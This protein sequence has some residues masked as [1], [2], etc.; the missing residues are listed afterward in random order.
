MKPFE[1]VQIVQEFSTAGGV[2]TVAWG[3]AGAFSRAGITNAVVAATA[4]QGSD[5]RTDIRR[6]AGWL[7]RVPTRGSLR[8]LGRLIVVPAFSIAATLAARRTPGSII[9]S[10]GDSLIGDILV[11]HAVNAESLAAKRADGQWAWIFNPMHYWIMLRDH[12]MI[13]GLRCKQYVAVSNRVAGE[14]RDHFAVPA[15]RICVIP[16]GIDLERFAH[17]PKARR[18]VRQRHAIPEDARVLLFVGHEFQRKGLAFVLD[19][20]AQL[21]DPPWLMVVGSDNPA[22]YRERAGTNA[23]RVVFAGARSDVD[24]YYSAADA[25]ILPTAYETFSLV[26]MEALA[27]GL[28]ILATAAGGIEDYL[29]DGHNGFVITR[30]GER[31]A[32]LLTRLFADPERMAE[33]KA[34]ARATAQRFG[35]DAIAQSYIALAAEMVSRAPEN[36]LQHAKSGVP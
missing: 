19:A 1:I 17:R 3:L 30:D 34:R 28:P 31:I 8:Y 36:A 21:P 4:S 24:A 6:V 7:S 33:M 18:D 15:E 16:N 26:C 11:V 27:A 14:L 20:L 32:S 2:E 13:R 23:G 25:F 22:P 5:P 9:I 29:E 10:H 12:L 35:W